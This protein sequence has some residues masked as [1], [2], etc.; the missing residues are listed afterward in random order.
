MMLFLPPEHNLYRARP[1]ARPPARMGLQTPPLALEE[2]EGGFFC[3][4]RFLAHHATVMSVGG[5]YSPKE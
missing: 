5:K 4:L 1:P 2:S 3:G